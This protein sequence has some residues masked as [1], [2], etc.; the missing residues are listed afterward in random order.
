MTPLP[1][2]GGVGERQYD[3]I[4][5]SPSPN[6]SRKRE[7]DLFADTADKL[8]GQCAVMLGWR[9][10]EFWTATPTELACVLRAL[11]PECDDPADSNLVTRMMEMYPDG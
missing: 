3:V 8:C 7:G 4:A 2:A 9:P 6:P 10:D 5:S 1:L 11:R